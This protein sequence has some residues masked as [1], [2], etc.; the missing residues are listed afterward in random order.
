MCCP[1]LSA[2]SCRKLVTSDA[3]RTN[4][5]AMKSTLFL[6]P[7]LT[8]SSTSFSVN[9][10]SSTLTPGKFMFLRSPMAALFSILHVTSPASA[11]ILTTVKTK[12]P[13]ATKMGCPGR[14]DSQSFL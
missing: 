8:M 1:L 5:A 10:G 3:L 12:L 9:V 13:S 2:K 14:T 7:K 6:M 4:D 11:L